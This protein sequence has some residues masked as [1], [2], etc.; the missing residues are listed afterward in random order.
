MKLKKQYVVIGIIYL[1]IF[2]AYMYSDILITTSH[3]INF[4]DILFQ[5]KIR[6]FYNL[7]I[8]D[9]DNSAYQIYNEAGYDI[10]IYIIFAIWNFPLWLIKHFFKINIWHS[11]LAM[12]WAKSLVLFFCILNWKAILKICKK[13]NMN[14]QQLHTVSLLLISSPLLFSCVFVFSQ[15]DVIYLFFVL[16][17]V[18]YYLDDNDKMFLGM[19]AI[20]IPIKPL[21]A[22]VFPPLILYKEKNVFKIMGQTFCI[23]SPWALLK[24]I[25]PAKFGAGYVLVFMLFKNKIVVEFEAISLFVLLNIAFYILCYCIK[26]NEISF[27]K[28]VI[29]I[30]Y[31][32]FYVFLSVC[33]GSPYWYILMLPF[34]IILIC[35]NWENRYISAILETCYSLCIIAYHVWQIPWGFDAKLVRSTYIGKVFGQREDYS[36]T[37]L[38]IFHTY[39]P[40]LYD[41]ADGRVKGY[42]F[43]LF[44]VIS[45]VFIYINVVRSESE[46]SLSNTEIPKTFYYIRLIACFGVGMIPMIAYVF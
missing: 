33:I 12:I 4:W 43:G 35:A 17:A 5:G 41:L 28:N 20:A 11:A 10:L 26:F 29:Q 32:S 19:M 1:L 44:L 39:C 36:D 15:Y 25:L 16:L 2:Y 23:L 6:D 40:T 3:G 31:L 24:V 21:A 18:Y 27:K 46:F 14:E 7:C 37:V 34:Q 38:D 9:I 30:C 8:S 22:F 13:M 45:L 42:L